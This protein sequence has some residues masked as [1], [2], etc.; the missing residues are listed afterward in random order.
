[1]TVKPNPDHPATPCREYRGKRT[2]DGYGRRGRVLL[3]RWIVEQIEGR[4][5]ELG[6]IVMHSCDNP[7]CFLYEHL[8]RATQSIN[9]RDAMAKGRHR[10]VTHRGESNGGGGKLIES[11]VREIKRRYRRGRSHHP[12]NQAE[13][14]AEFGVSVSCIKKI[15]TDQLWSHV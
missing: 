6:E 2:K 4:P 9:I 1:M 13:L 7:P 15:V 14:A 8:S 12:G 11:Q 3:H 5:L 10:F